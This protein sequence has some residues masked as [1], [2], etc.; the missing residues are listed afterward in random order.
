MNI[1][2]DLSKGKILNKT[3]DK[4]YEQKPQTKDFCTEMKYFKSF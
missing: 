1:S 2:N 3:K 4:W